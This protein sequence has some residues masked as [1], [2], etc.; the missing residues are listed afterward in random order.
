MKKLLS[1]EVGWFQPQVLGNQDT[2][3]QMQFLTEKK[4]KSEILTLKCKTVIGANFLAPVVCIT[5]LL[6]YDA[7]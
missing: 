2:N 1:L 7:V 5:Q 4:S 6:P 3:Q